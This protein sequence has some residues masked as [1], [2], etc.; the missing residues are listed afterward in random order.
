MSVPAYPVPRDLLKGKAVVVTAAADANEAATLRTAGAEVLCVPG[1][2]GTIDLK[3]LLQQLAAREVNELLVE[4]GATLCGALLKAGLVDELVVYLAPHLLGDNGRGMFSL[5]G[6]ETM[7]DRI[8][9]DIQDIRAL[10][11]D[12][13]ITAGVKNA[14]P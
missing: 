7:T 11:K 8:A 4:A 2:E 3:A 1:G 5:P 14:S 6:I 13:R 12:W 9:I 10:G